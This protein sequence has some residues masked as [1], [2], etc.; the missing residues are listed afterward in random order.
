MLVD[1]SSRQYIS[2][3]LRHSHAPNY[4]LLEIKIQY[5]MDSPKPQTRAHDKFLHRLTQT[6]AVDALPL[7]HDGGSRDCCLRLHAKVPLMK[8]TPVLIS[9]VAPYDIYFDGGLTCDTDGLPFL[10]L[11]FS[12]Y[13]PGGLVGFVLKPIL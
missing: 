9:N 7:D 3:G 13:S 11:W 8:K 10:P 12:N 2:Q 1:R 4:E 5:G 6:V